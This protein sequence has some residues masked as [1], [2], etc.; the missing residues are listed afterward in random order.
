MHFLY[1]DEAGSTGGDLKAAQQPVFVMAS[2]VVSDEK[3]RRANQAVRDKLEDY[4]GEAIAP[5]FEL[6][7]YEL[8]SPNGDGPFS[9]HD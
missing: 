4:L 9:G 2:L 1:I 8:L 3:W 5:G 6:H 7:A